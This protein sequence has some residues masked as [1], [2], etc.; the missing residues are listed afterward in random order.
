MMTLFGRQTLAPAAVL[1]VFLFG[2]VQSRGAAGPGGQPGSGWSP[3]QISGQGVVV[4]P[5][6]NTLEVRSFANGDGILWNIP[7]GISGNPSAFINAHPNEFVFIGGQLNLNP[8]RTEEV[9]SFTNVNYMYF[10]QAATPPTPDP[11]HTAIYIKNDG[12]LYK[13]SSDGVEVQISGVGGGGGGGVLDAGYGPS[14]DGQIAT[15]PSMNSVFDQV[16]TM[17]SNEAYGPSWLSSTR[18]APSREAVFNKIES[19]APPTTIVTSMNT[20]TNDN[21]LIVSDGLARTGEKWVKAS[22][23]SLDGAGNLVA[24]TVSVTNSAYNSTWTN[25]NFTVP[26]KAAVATRIE[27]IVNSGP[28][29]AVNPFATN[30]L[31]TRVDT[32]SSSRGLKAIAS[33]AFDDGTLSNT[34]SIYMKAN[35]TIIYPQNTRQ[36]F[37]PGSFSPGMN[38]GSYSGYPSSLVNGDIWF[39]TGFNCY[40][41]AAGSGSTV[42]AISQRDEINLDLRNFKAS[43]SPAPV[44]DQTEDADK[45]TFVDDQTSGIQCQFPI[46]HS[47]GSAANIAIMF[48]MTTA[49]NNNVV[50]G[51]QT[52]QSFFGNA[53]AVNG[54]GYTA[55]TDLSGAPAAAL[56]GGLCYANGSLPMDGVTGVGNA[57][58]FK[59]RI[60][61]RGAVAGDTAVGDVKL[62]A[63]RIDWI[64]N[65]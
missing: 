33:Y 36:S 7:D 58:L 46:G 25:G 48:S 37:N 19:M 4:H 44:F 27:Q 52:M 6:G 11:G 47:W 49:T 30:Y 15:A 42:F 21:R 39:Y 43:G 45:W 23:A 13:I 50:W 41:A 14:W 20:F 54:S 2:V 63:V 57:V 64:R 51:L 9:S 56:L 1:A 38:V 29:T 5:P 22:A 32:S 53:E 10:F 55:I 60:Y 34:A 3:S 59:L 61:R 24:E 26:T 12:N 65:R 18:T 17:V 62:H 28:V 35:G 16:E 40:F 8:G 31:M